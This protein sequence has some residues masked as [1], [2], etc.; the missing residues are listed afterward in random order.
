MST[1]GLTDPVLYDRGYGMAVLADYIE[2][3][4]GSSLGFPAWAVFTPDLEAIGGGIGF[5]SW[6]SVAAIIDDDRE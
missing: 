5:S 1:H 6:D 2:E 4:D 3:A